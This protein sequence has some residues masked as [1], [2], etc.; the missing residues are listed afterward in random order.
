LETSTSWN[1]QGLS[2][3]V[4]GLLFTLS[5]I[6]TQQLLRYKT[7]HLLGRKARPLKLLCSLSETTC[8]FTVICWCVFCPRRC[9]F[10]RSVASV[11]ARN[12][13]YLPCVVM[14]IIFLAPA[15]RNTVSC[16]VF[17]LFFMWDKLV[18]SFVHPRVRD[19]KV[20]NF[21]GVMWE[22]CGVLREEP[23]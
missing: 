8:I 22:K 17:F 3:P 20:W 13:K 10:V 2:K 18:S 14:T 6:A 1:P 11:L 21:G 19:G 4:I 5:L 7:S 16:L 15:S 12:R 23:V 9:K